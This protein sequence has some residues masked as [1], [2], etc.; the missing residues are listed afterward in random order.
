[1]NYKTV[2][3]SD[4]KEASNRNTWPFKDMAINQVIQ[5]NKELSLKAQTAC[6]SYGKMYGMKFKTRTIK[7]TGECLVK[8]IA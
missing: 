7:D 8:R 3:S 4:F 6:H 2:T 5:F 1:M